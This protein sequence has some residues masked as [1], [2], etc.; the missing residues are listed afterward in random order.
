[1]N[2]ATAL[3]QGALLEVLD[4]L[5]NADAGDRITQAPPWPSA[6]SRLSNQWYYNPA[7]F[8]IM[9]DCANALIGV[10]SE[11]SLY[12]AVVVAVYGQPN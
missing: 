9:Q 5:R 3:D 7:Y 6:A 10:W 4:A 2:I 1:M 12:R 8:A 11:N